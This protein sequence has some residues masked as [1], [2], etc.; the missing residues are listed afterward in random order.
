MPED[1]QPHEAA[2][3]M[4]A[5]LGRRL[6]A[7]AQDRPEVTV[8]VAESCT[9]GWV[10]QAITAVPGS[11]G[12]FVGGVIAYSDAAKR[13]LLG[14]DSDTLGAHG[15]VSSETAAAMAAGARERLEASVAVSVTGIAGPGGGSSAKPVGLVV[16]AVAG[17]DGVASLAR[18]FGP[19]ATSPWG[20]EITRRADVR[21]A[22]VVAALE[23]I[24][25][26]VTAVP[27]TP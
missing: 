4:I 26:A 21:A 11:S 7:A 22:A 25:E 15:A 19:A 3:D 5:A 9:G 23:L 12:Y 17:S 16:F 6:A 10:G 2:Q 20:E 18:Q 13:S 8:A 14:V 1:D 27:S 24:E